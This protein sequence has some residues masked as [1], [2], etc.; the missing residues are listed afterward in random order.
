MGRLCKLQELFRLQGICEAEV[1]GSQEIGWKESLYFW[2]RFH[3][4]KA[5]LLIEGVSM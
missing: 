2:L 3:S 1:N 5:D 4:N